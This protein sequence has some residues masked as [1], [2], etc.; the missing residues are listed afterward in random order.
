MFRQMRRNRQLLSD[1]RAISIL[2]NGKTGVLAVLGD[3]DYPY[4][5]PVNYV[6][7][8]NRIYIHCA[9]TGHKI[10]AINKHQKVS[11]CVVSKDDIIQEKYTTYF[12]SV[13][14]FGKARLLDDY[15]EI[16][17]AVTI[18]AEKYCPDFADGIEKE[19][20]REIPAV[21][22]I[23]IEIDYLTGK[24]AKELINA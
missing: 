4:T 5:V 20:E 16:K 22:V 2:Q 1:D 9:K 18:L 12:E 11:F 10:D 8:N 19:V 14:A 24:Q 13:V 15:S 17:Q 6:Y 23:E 7:F 21:A 3:N